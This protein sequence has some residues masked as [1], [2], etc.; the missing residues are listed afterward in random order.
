MN[1]KKF[2]Y[3][4]GEDDGVTARTYADDILLFEKSYESIVTLVEVVQDFIRQSIL[5]LNP[6]K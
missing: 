3:W 6:K 5:K 2:G 1:L 4:W